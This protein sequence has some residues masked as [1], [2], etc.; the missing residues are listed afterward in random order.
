MLTVASIFL[1]E[2][3]PVKTPPDF[4]L[5]T[6]IQWG[7][8]WNFAGRCLS[9]TIVPIFIGGQCFDTPGGM[10]PPMCKVC[11]WLIGVGGLV[12]GLGAGL[13]LASRRR[14]APTIDP[15]ARPPESVRSARSQ[16]H[17]ALLAP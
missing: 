13:L 17:S 1:T 4:P 6:T 9:Q 15:G 7:C 8:G 2:I 11:V 12:L 10:G 5:L 14:R 3:K 16:R